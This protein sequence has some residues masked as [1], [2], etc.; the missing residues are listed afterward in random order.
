MSALKS[1]LLTNLRSWSA[2]DQFTDTAQVWRNVS[3]ATTNG[4]QKDDWRRIYAA[5][6]GRLGAG[7]STEP[8]IGGGV[9]E[10]SGNTWHCAPDADV[11]PKDRLIVSGQRF[12][13]IGADDKR[14]DAIAL[15]VNIVKT[16]SK[17]TP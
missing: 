10:R 13:V 16:A 6:P 1:A 4:G 14:T 3:A 9:A 2:S 17:G 12:D 11:Q 7:A 8:V 5:L 15:H